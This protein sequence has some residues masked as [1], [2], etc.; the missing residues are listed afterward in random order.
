MHAIDK[1]LRVRQTITKTRILAQEFSHRG[2]KI[3]KISKWFTFFIFN[4]ILNLKRE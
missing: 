2:T 4:L 1:Q 3:K